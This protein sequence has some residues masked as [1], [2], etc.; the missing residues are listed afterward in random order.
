MARPPR[1]GNHK[2]RI[3]RELFHLWLWDSRGR[4]NRVSMSQAEIAQRL[5]CSPS[6]PTRIFSELIATGRIIRL[7]DGSFQVVDPAE[8]PKI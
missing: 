3:D 2:G 4:N 6:T 7:R 8:C 1:K 5:K